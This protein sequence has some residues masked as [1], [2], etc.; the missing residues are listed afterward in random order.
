MNQEEKHD[1]FTIKSC[2]I[3]HGKRFSCDFVKYERQKQAFNDTCRDCIKSSSAN[4]EKSISYQKYV[5]ELLIN[6]EKMPDIQLLL[7]TV[8]TLLTV[9]SSPAKKEDI[10][11]RFGN[12]KCFIT[13]PKFIAGNLDKEKITMIQQLLQKYVEI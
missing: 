8:L 12:N 9:A 1:R 10:K 11:F 4:D 6:D 5:I 13:L 2:L 7:Y 3:C